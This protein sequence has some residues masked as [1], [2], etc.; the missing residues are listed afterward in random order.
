MKKGL[1]TL[2]LPLVA[3]VAD[4]YV[5][6]SGP[7]YDITGYRVKNGLFDYNVIVMKDENDKIRFAKNGV[8][9]EVDTFINGKKTDPEDTASYMAYNEWYKSIKR[10][11]EFREWNEVALKVHE[12][13]MKRK[14]RMEK[15]QERVE[16]RYERRKERRISK[17]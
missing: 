15:K 16:R 4:G 6:N 2:M 12:D 17:E 3:V 5:L 8:G 11:I 7:K 10:I 1:I 14:A 13:A 9:D